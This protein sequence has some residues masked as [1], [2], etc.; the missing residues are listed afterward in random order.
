V[1][2]QWPEAIVFA[3]VVPVF[4]WFY[5]RLEKQRHAAVHQRAAHYP[6]SARLAAD[7]PFARHVPLLLFLASLTLLSVAL[8]RPQALMTIFAV[9][10][11]AVLAVDVSTSMKVNDALPSRLARSQ[12]LAKEFV[13]KHSDELRIGLVSFGGNAVAEIDPTTDREE[14]FAA[15]DRLAPRPGTAIGRGIATALSMIFPEAGI[16]T[17]AGSSARSTALSGRRIDTRPR[18]QR[19]DPAPGSYSAAAIVLISDGQSARGPD[20]I[21][22]A[23]L[24][25]DLGVRVHTIGIGSIQGRAMSVNGWSM[26]VR[27]DEAALKEI[28]TSTQGRYFSEKTGIDWRWILESIRPDLPPEETYTEITALF[29]AA[30]ALAAIAG[31]LLSLTWT[32]RIL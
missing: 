24:A 7:R 6:H 29:A 9:R 8:A 14:L 28:A 16:D 5:I 21:E 23:R 11:T 4:L 26:R 2:F 1:T 13:A 10:G 27:L 30:A 3:L 31:A 32:K 19:V 15:I 17:R 22:V 18:A 25:A 12:A 20:P